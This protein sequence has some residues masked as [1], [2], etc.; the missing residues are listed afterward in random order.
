MW[1][2]VKG[3]FYSVC[4]Y[5]YAYI[6]IYIYI[7]VYTRIHQSYRNIPDIQ[8]CIRMHTY[9]VM[10][11]IHNDIHI[12]RAIIRPAA[13]LVACSPVCWPPLSAGLVCSPAACAC[14][15]LRRRVTNESPSTAL[16]RRATPAARTR[17]QSQR[18]CLRH[19][20]AGRAT[21]KQTHNYT[22][23]H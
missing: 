9:M 6:Y 18:A 15:R 17:P 23:F 2:K 20:A 16:R 12:L 1:R 8:R 14:F 19:V 3:S 21:Q 11:K 5:T 22:C 13:R 4:V 7:N 10:F